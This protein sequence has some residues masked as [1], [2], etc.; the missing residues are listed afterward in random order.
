MFKE[1]LKQLRTEQGLTQKELAEIIF[2]SRSAICKWEMGNGYPS[3]VN[4]EALCEY[5]KVEEKWLMDRDDLKENVKIEK[6]KGKKILS[7]IV[8]IISIIMF[9]LTIVPVHTVATWTSWYHKFY[10]IIYI[11]TWHS[12]I[13]EILI[14]I[15]FITSIINLKLLKKEKYKY[16]SLLTIIM[17]ASVVIAF[18]I[19]ELYSLYTTE[20]AINNSILDRFL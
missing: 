13:L 3:D 14:L 12:L 18:V 17:I 4:L 20:Y 9:I 8:L 1:K 16:S 10:S 11:Y 5:F 15:P 19:L 6:K 7:I 2:V